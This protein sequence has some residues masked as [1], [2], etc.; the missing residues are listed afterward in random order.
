MDMRDTLRDIALPFVMGAMVAGGVFAYDRVA[1]PIA[2]YERR[3]PSFD[4]MVATEVSMSDPDHLLPDLVP[5]PARDLTL[6]VGANGHLQLLFSTTYYN[7]GTGPLELRADPSTTGI[8]DDIDRVVSQRVYAKDGTFTDR[9]VG[10]FRWHQTHLHYHFSDFVS[11]ILTS[12][13]AQSDPIR[14]EKATFCIRDVSRLKQD[15]PDKKSPATYTIC[16]KERQ[17]VSV[18]WADTYYYN[19]PDQSIDLN[20][21]P[22]GTYRLSFVVNPAGA[23]REQAYLNNRSYVVFAFNK[24]DHT[25]TIQKEFPE[26]P[27]EVEHVHLDDPFGM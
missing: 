23:L 5:L 10:V 26:H 22:T 1:T 25:V 17:G 13:S 15:M 20:D 6:S 19:Y 18:G 21:I 3:V 16:G 14:L 27:P 12:E 24:E 11:Y 8:F 9:K 7:Q 4:E 2:L